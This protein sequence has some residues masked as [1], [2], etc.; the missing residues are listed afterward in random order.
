VRALGCFLDPPSMV[1]FCYTKVVSLTYVPLQHCQNHNHHCLANNFALNPRGLT[2]PIRVEPSKIKPSS[3]TERVGVR[4]RSGVQLLFL[5]TATGKNYLSKEEERKRE[6]VG[7]ATKIPRN[8]MAKEGG[9]EVVVEITDEDQLRIRAKRVN[10][11]VGVPL[12]ELSEETILK[13]LEK[14]IDVWCKESN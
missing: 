4:E 6:T 10:Y 1:V 3:L 13:R 14:A 7:M 5:P 12:K 2:T 11:A 8:K 9:I